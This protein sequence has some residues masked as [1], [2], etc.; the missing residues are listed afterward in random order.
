MNNLRRRN[1]H[2][3]KK[4][5]ITRKLE[6]GFTL[7]EVVIA[8][9]IM[10]VI[11]VTAYSTLNYIIRSKKL[12]DD[13]RDI[14]A[15]ANSIL[16]R[17]SR[18][19]Q[20]ASNSDPLV[21]PPSGSTTG[22]PRL[23]LEGIQ[24]NLP[25]GARGDNLTFMAREAGQYVPGGLSNPGAVMIRYRLEKDP[26]SPSGE[27]SSYILIRD[28]VPNVKPPKRAWERLMT[29]PIAHNVV[30]LEF[31]Y[32]NPLN[33]RWTPEWNIS[34]PRIPGLVRLVLGL[35]SPSGAVH[36]FVTVLALKFENS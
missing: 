36:Q 18:E 15:L 31:S 9:S 27:G 1:I 3:Q 5:R 16:L 12:L 25:T 35:R 34:N 29:F 4:G 32:Y 10:S 22:T 23:Y 20:L 24:N 30:Q 8:V 6:Y 14:S 13:R 17:V 33:Q 2:D 19:I 11:L 21:P 7:V 28:E 26:D